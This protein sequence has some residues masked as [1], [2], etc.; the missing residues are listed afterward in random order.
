[1]VTVPRVEVPVQ[2]GVNPAGRL[3]KVAPVAPVVLYDM[4]VMAEPRQRVWA[5]EP[6]AEARVMVFATF[7]VIVIGLEVAVELVWQLVTLE[8]ITTVTT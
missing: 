7:T 4:V 3:L 6:D 8:V 1:M 5:V 2:V